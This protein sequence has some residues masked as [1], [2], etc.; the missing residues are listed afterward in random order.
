ME[1]ENLRGWRMI[2]SLRRPLT[3]PGIVMMYLGVHGSLRVLSARTASLLPQERFL[4]QNPE[5]CYEFGEVTAGNGLPNHDMGGGCVVYTTT[6]STHS[7]TI[8]GVSY[9]LESNSLY[10]RIVSLVNSTSG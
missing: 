4:G 6:S 8:P 7:Y 1:N 3:E 9:D 2:S 5:G 10:F